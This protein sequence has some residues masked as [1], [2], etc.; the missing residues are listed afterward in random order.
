MLALLF[1]PLGRLLLGGL[2]LLAVVGGLY[3]KVYSDGA[4][5]ERAKQ[6]R[7]TL[8]N[9]RDRIKTDEK[10]DKLPAPDLDNELSRWMLPD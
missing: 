8:E 9:L 10:V 3:L 5:S 4:A 2:A 6:E 7:A 1:S